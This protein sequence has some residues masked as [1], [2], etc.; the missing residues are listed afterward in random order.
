MSEKLYFVV[1]VDLETGEVEIDDDTAVARFHDGLVWSD[2]LG[3]WRAE[4][5]AEYER[6]VAKLR[7]MLD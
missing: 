1:A 7:P 5:E 2:E 4:T 3:E 6:S